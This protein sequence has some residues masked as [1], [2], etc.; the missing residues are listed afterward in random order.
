MLALTRPLFVMLL[1]MFP[2]M[3]LNIDPPA[4]VLSDSSAASNALSASTSLAQTFVVSSAGP[5]A[6]PS[7]SNIPH[8]PSAKG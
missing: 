1:K 4:I 5:T 8:R 6:P 7:I 2:I 3:F